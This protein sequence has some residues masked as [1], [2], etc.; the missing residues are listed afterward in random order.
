MHT[1]PLVSIITGVFNGQRTLEDCY[2]T[3][4]RQ[5]YKNFEWLIVDDRSTDNSLSMISHWQDARIRVLQTAVNSGGP[6]VP[7]NLAVAHSK[8]DY[9]AILDQDDVWDAD[10]LERQLEFMEGHKE[11]A[12]LSSNLRVSGGSEPRGNRRGIRKRGLI[13]PGPDEI[14]RENPFLSSAI[15]MRRVAV[16]DVGGFDEHPEVCGRDEWE[17]AIRISLKY[18]TASNGDHIAGIHRLHQSNLSHSISSFAGMDYV[19]NKHDHYFSDSLVRDVRARDCYNRARDALNSGALA[20]FDE[21]ISKAASYRFYY[22][23]KGL[24]LRYKKLLRQ[25]L[26]RAKSS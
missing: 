26:A 16:E 7:R 2:H 13:Y 24:F 8:G 19:R 23:W 5:T 22:Q 14:Y 3:V 17:L 21:Q 20:I 11:V 1:T 12:L 10:K 25:I 6:A 4:I 18:R 15:I 9:I